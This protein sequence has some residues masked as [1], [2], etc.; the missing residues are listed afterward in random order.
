[1]TFATP[2]NTPLYTYI[3]VYIWSVL[4]IEMPMYGDAPAPIIELFSCVGGVA[5][6]MQAVNRFSDLGHKVKKV[7]KDRLM[8]RV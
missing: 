5:T 3:Y 8:R 2:I 6:K 1:M 4:A 7:L